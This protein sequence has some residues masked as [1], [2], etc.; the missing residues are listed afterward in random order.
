MVVEPAKTRNP[1]ALLEFQQ[2]RRKHG[3]LARLVGNKQRE[4]RP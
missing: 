1:N 2:N 3:V 4:P